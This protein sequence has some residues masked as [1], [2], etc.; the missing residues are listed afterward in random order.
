MLPLIKLASK[1]AYFASLE[2]LKISRTAIKQETKKDGSPVTQ[3]DLRANNAI[4]EI[5]G[6]T[7]IPIISE[8]SAGIPYKQRVGA[9][10]LWMIDPLDGTKEFIAGNG[11][12]TVNIALIHKD[13]ATAGVIA[14]PETGVLYLG[15]ESVGIL[16]TTFKAIQEDLQLSD[17]QTTDHPARPDVGLLRIAVSRSHPDPH[18]R[19]MIKRLKEENLTV[20]EIPRGSSLKF[21]EI[22]SGKADI[23]LRHSPTSEWDSA[24]GDAIVHAAGGL[25]VS[26]PSGDPLAYNKP[27]LINPPFV[28]FRHQALSDR[29]LKILSPQI[30]V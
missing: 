7:S 15:I 24:A 25:T 17:F 10:W 8:E 16:E 19:E 4:C 23:Y 22:A 30:G 20:E 21:C 18:T 12:Y 3:A 2:I 1:A 29:F 27:K 5:L 28:S 9:E 11:E 26:M 14:I 6:K 13:R